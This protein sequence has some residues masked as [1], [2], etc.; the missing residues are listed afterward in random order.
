VSTSKKGR[1]DVKTRFAPPS[2]PFQKRSRGWGQRS[3]NWEGNRRERTGGILFTTYL[4]IGVGSRK[5]KER[6]PAGPPAGSPRYRQVRRIYLREGPYLL[7]EAVPCG[8]NTLFRSQPQ[9]R[10]NVFANYETTCTPEIICGFRASNTRGTESKKPHKA[11][12]FDPLTGWSPRRAFFFL[13]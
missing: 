12:A 7:G 6:R 5:A 4:I 13:G 10:L 2:A 1:L 11:W 9:S 3:E 8:E